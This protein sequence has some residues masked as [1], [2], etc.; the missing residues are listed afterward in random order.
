MKNKLEM[1]CNDF[2]DNHY[3]N[4][5]LSSWIDEMYWGDN[6]TTDR[7]FEDMVSKAA[8]LNVKLT[9]VDDWD[10]DRHFYDVWSST[11]KGLS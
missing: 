3:D 2:F 5:E 4:D 1:T 6:F 10:Y 9:D 8:T 11:E 7:L